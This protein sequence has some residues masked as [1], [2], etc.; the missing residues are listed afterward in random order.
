MVGRGDPHGIDGLVVEHA[1]HVLGRLRLVAAELFGGFNRLAEA[2]LV[3]VAHPGHVHL[4][5]LAQQPQ[6]IAT[7]AAGANHADR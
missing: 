4:L 6:V 1:A 7:H 5:V 2:Q 3:D